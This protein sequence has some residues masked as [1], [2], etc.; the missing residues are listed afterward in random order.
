MSKYTKGPWFRDSYTDGGPFHVMNADGY[1]IAD[2]A[3]EYSSIEDPE[4]HE[5]NAR[6]IVA[7]PELLDELVLILEWARIEK[8]PLRDMEIERIA[9]LI[10]K[11]TGDD[12]A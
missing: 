5:A 1:A 7:A 11:A 8:A 4:V 6:L 9:A 2:M 10:D 12:N 3:L